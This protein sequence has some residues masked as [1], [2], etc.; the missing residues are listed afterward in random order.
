MPG[1]KANL[2]Y[3]ESQKQTF[4]RRY[5]TGSWAWKKW[6]IIANSLPSRLYFCFP[7]SNPLIILADVYTYYFSINRIVILLDPT[8]LLQV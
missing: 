6:R 1:R 4:L 8:K 3:T 2:F 5:S 7:H